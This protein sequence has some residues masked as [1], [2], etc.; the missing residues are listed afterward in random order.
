M[1]GSMVYLIIIDHTVL[2]I[3]LNKEN[4]QISGLEP[5]TTVKPIKWITFFSLN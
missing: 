3:T 5:K 4:L 1:K 2:K